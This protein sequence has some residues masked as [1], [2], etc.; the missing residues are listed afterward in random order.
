[1]YLQSWS[2]EHYYCNGLNP[3]SGERARL[4][5]LGDSSRTLPIVEP[6]SVGGGTVPIILAVHETPAGTGGQISGL[7]G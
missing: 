2:F 4:R 1:M 7:G 3:V 5:A 6:V